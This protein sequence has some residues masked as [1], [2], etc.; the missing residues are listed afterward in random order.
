CDNCGLNSRHR[1]LLVLSSKGGGWCS[2]W[3][4]SSLKEI[5]NTYRE[6]IFLDYDEVGHISIYDRTGS[7]I[8]D[9]FKLNVTVSL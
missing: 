8:T 5:A 1:F 9:K 3:T 2:F 7:D 6:Q 4:T